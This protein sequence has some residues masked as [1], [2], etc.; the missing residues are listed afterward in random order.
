MMHIGCQL[1]EWMKCTAQPPEHLKSP[2]REKLFCNKP[3]SRF[4]AGNSV[5][6]KNYRA[7]PI[8]AAWYD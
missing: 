2:D 7:G 6:G 5:S 1:K 8:S 3:E 4:H